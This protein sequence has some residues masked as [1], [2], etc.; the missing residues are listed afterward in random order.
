MLDAVDLPDDIAALKA[1]LI[2]AQL[3]EVREDDRIELL[4]KLVAAFKQ[5]A[6]G[7]KSEKADPQHFDLALGT[8]K[9]PSLP[10]KPRTTPTALRASRHAPPIAAPFPSRAEKG[11]SRR[12]DYKKRKFAHEFLSQGWF[13]FRFW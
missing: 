9:R 12:R 4:E 8:S 3:R 5:A 11:Y 13:Y 10:S 6:F 1:M 2:A 7:R